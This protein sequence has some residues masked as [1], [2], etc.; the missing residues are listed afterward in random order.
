MTS[1]PTTI[2][3]EAYLSEAARLM[4]KKK[5]KRLPV[6]DGNNHLVGVLSRLDILKVLAAG[7]LPQGISSQPFGFRPPSPR[8]VSDVMDSNV[9]TASAHTLLT[10]V[11]ACLAGTRMKRVVVVDDEQRV[12]GIISETDLVARMSPETHPGILEQLVSRLPLGSRSAEARSHLQ[13][14]RSKTATDLMTEPVI[15]LRADESIATAV[16]LS[17]EK[18]IKRF[19]VVNA[20]GKLVGIVGRE[21]LL[22]ALVSELP[23]AKESDRAG[24]Q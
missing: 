3:P 10:E 12:K 24:E 1:E 22:S 6:V 5:L 9:P 14:A 4:A 7:Y 8:T 15:T 11:L 16:A 21:E 17:A 23:K 2:G 13:K 20:A 18:H 19:P